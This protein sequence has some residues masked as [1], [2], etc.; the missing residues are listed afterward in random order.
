M[1]LVNQ[2]VY[3]MVLYL[4]AHNESF[5]EISAVL[6]TII[7][8]LAALCLIYTCIQQTLF[9][10]L[11]TILPHFLNFPN[12]RCTHVN[13]LHVETVKYLINKNY[14]SLITIN[15]KNCTH[16]CLMM[17]GFFWRSTNKSS[18]SIRNKS[19][20]PRLHKKQNIEI[21]SSAS[22]R[23]KGKYMKYVRFP[24]PLCQAALATL[25]VSLFH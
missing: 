1:D 12:T 7:S 20:L 5:H 2:F 16:S 17:S 8:I 3:S 22:Y 13:N 18:R 23:G 14:C 4:L 10:T 24:W 15:I 21:N 9:Q 6:N 11:Y 19:F 25:N